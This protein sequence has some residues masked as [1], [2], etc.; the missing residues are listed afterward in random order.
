MLISAIRRER[1]LDCFCPSACPNGSVASLDNNAAKQTKNGPPIGVLSVRSIADKDAMKMQV[2][3][4]RR[5]DNLTEGKKL[6]VRI[7][8]SSAIKNNDALD[9]KSVRVLAKNRTVA[10]VIRTNDM[11]MLLR[12]FMLILYKKSPP[13][14]G[15]FLR[16]N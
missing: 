4:G 6:I 16:D 11:I 13:E 7:I 9:D 5:L 1:I 10:I 12:S 3:A 15:V 8:S 2:K 14:R